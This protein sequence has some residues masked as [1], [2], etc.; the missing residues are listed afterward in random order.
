VAKAISAQVRRLALPPS[1]VTLSS[2]YSGGRQV[3]R[4]DVVRPALTVLVLF[5]LLYLA[6]GAVGLFYGYPLDLALFESTSASATVGLSIGI[7]GPTMPT[8]LKVTYILQMWM[9]RLEFMAVFA[10]AAFA[11]SAFRGRV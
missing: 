6:G 4:D 10:L 8:L 7:T 5:I 3:L 9:G 1:A 11:V 2:Y